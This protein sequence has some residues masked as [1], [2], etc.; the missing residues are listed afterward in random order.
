MK[1]ISEEEFDETHKTEFNQILIGRLNKN[2][3]Q[4]SPEDM[5][6]FGG[7]MYE[8]Y[9]D[10]IKYVLNFVEA[11]RVVTIVESESD[12]ETDEDGSP[13]SCMFY[14]SGYHLVNR[15]GH[16]ILDEPYTED[17]QVKLDW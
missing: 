9:G 7:C 14:L 12:D 4:F 16:L 10:E 15:I 2:N 8:T 3:E 1:N 5:C 13:L 11:N 6:S 17:F